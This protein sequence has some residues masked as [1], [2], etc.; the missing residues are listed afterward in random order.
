VP[1]LQLFMFC[2]GCR[3]RGSQSGNFLR[4]GDPPTSRFGVRSVARHVLP[5]DHEG[6]HCY[7]RDSSPQ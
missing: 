7:P 2:L 6:C 1:D 5:R 4:F 3:G